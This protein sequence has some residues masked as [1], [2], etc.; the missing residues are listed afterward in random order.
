[1]ET[2]ISCDKEF[3]I[4]PHETCL[5]CGSFSGPKFLLSPFRGLTA[6]HRNNIIPKDHGCELVLLNISYAELEINSLDHEISRLQLSLAA[7]QK[8][9]DDLHKFAMQ[10][11]SYFAPIRRLPEEILRYIFFQEYVDYADYGLVACADRAP[12]RLI[13]QVSSH[14][15]SVAH[16]YPIL[17]SS[18]YIDTRNQP[19]NSVRMAVP[20]IEKC[21]LLSKESPLTLTFSGIFESSL[22]G[23]HCLQAIKQSA[24]RWGKIDIINQE[25]LQGIAAST[26]Y[27]YLRSLK[28]GTITRSFSLNPSPK[29]KKITISGARDSTLRIS[30]QSTPSLTH[31]NFIKIDSPFTMFT[32]LPWSQITHFTSDVNNFL[33]GEL[34]DMMRS[35][36]NLMFFKF[37]GFSPLSI[38]IVL[39]K[40]HTL[41]PG[42][43]GSY[44]QHSNEL[45]HFTVPSLKILHSERDFETDDIL[46]FLRRSKC[47]LDGLTI[48]SVALDERWL[49]EELNKVKK[50]CF[51]HPLPSRLFD[52]IYW[53]TR[54][55]DPGDEQPLFPQ[56]EVLDVQKIISDPEDTFV[57]DLVAMLTSQLP[58][59]SQMAPAGESRDGT[60]ETWLR[61]ATIAFKEEL[62]EDAANI[63]K[64]FL[65]SEVAQQPGVE[66][67]I[68][69][70][71]YRSRIRKY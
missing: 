54:G 53:L 6:S 51:Y 64:A 12:L 65:R 40:V 39:S 55:N 61:S 7:L 17:W 60:T 24:Y 52:D 71:S 20:F 45:E 1:M 66:V 19:R 11:R 5:A 36:P 23:D 28:I 34:S 26:T 32:D 38:P 56:L 50:L 21:I 18:I 49:A 67:T 63:V 69:Y 15:R 29:L 44:M 68:G 31:I 42:S 4:A 59:T 13:T 48:T 47:S 2:H 35:M 43:R 46:Q 33:D 16:S 9:R 27:S 8:R 62:H 58:P 30:L 22:L 14:W 70:Y 57:E 25:L 10:E 37:N 41:T 3:T